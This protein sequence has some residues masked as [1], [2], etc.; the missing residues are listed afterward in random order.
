[1]ERRYPNILVVSTGSLI[2][3]LT[4]KDAQIQGDK[5]D[6]DTQGRWVAA[7]IASRLRSPEMQGVEAVVVDSAKIDDQLT[8]LREAFESVFHVHL[9]APIEVLRDRFSSRDRDTDA[10]ISFDDALSHPTE[11]A[12][13][14]LRGKA[15]VL[16]DTSRLPPE[17]AS[18]MVGSFLG[19]H[20]QF[21]SPV[22]DVLIGGQY[23]SEGKGHIAHYLSTEYDLLVR[24]G[25]PNAGHT[26]YERP[27]SYTHHHLPSGTRNCQAKLVLGAGACLLLPRLLEEI[28][29]CE[30]SPERLTIDPQAMLI[31]A[32]DQKSEQALIRSIASTGQGVGYATARKVLRGNLK[33]RVT[34][35]RD[36]PELKPFVRETI[37]VFERAYADGGKIFLEGTQ[38][39]GLSLHHGLYPSVTSRDTSASGCLAEAGISPR[40]VRKII[41]VCRT[42]PIRVG[43]ES[44]EL[45]GEL[46]W[47]DIA[48]R[49][50]LD[51]DELKRVEK[52][53]T[54][55]RDRRV[56]E[57][58]WTMYRRAVSINGPTDIA[59]TFAD[60]V[61]SDNLNARRF[62]QLSEA[63]V[64]FVGELERVAGAPVSL[65]TTR[66]HF[67]SIIDRRAWR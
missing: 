55:G 9:H 57:F 36:V 13:Q 15:D 32:S 2:G 67:R 12:V 31:E 19:M 38:G 5:L 49:A 35:A 44:G 23:G 26:I 1:M 56:G 40:Y 21:K 53:S 41:M 16:I 8:G 24:V 27:R 47:D 34:L 20:G 66:F 48:Q 37:P 50:R 45:R 46:T 61:D 65:I 3:E 30:V 62:E 18:V 52:G 60:Y 11:A 28:N 29:Q 39:T 6:E 17:D 63:T 58:D 42:Y 33:P 10:S 14:E 43:G 59:L 51:P 25:G 54:T 4:R 7:A 64:S 22:V